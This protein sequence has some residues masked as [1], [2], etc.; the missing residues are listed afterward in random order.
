MRIALALAVLVAIGGVAYAHQSSIKYVDI[1]VENDRAVARATISPSDVTQPLGLDEAAKP[2]VAEALAPASLDRMTAFVASWIA[3]RTPDGAACTIAAPRAAADADAK[4]IDV[5][6]DVTC[7]A[8]IEKLVLDFTRFFA[9]DQRHEA[10][11]SVHAP[12]EHVEPI[13]VRISDPI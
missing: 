8:K 6:W 3:I 13:V 2:S 1:T 10:I 7:G 4:F 9:L 11:V 5:T 12:G